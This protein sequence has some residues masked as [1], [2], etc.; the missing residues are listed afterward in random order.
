MEEKVHTGITKA[1]MERHGDYD[2]FLARHNKETRRRSTDECYTPAAVYDAVLAWVLANCPSVR[3]KKIVRPF[4]PEGDYKAEDYTDAVVIDNP[5]FFMEHQITTWYVRHGVPFFL[6]APALTLFT[7]ATVK[8]Q[9]TY[10]ATNAEVFYEHD[11]QIKVPIK[12]SFITNIEDLA[13][14]QLVTAPDLREAIMKAQSQNKGEYVP[15]KTEYHKNIVTPYRLSRV[16]EAGIQMRIPREEAAW[17]RGNVM[18][19]GRY[20]IYGGA[21]VVSDRHAAI[22]EKCNR[23]PE[24]KVRMYTPSD[25]A[26]N[27]V[28]GICSK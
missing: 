4:R 21:F 14:Y 23:K 17:W 27:K 8:D 13:S 20:N 1:Q 28:N 15:T 24:P 18:E 16:A 12:T 6:F 22:V 9:L 3:G 25:E 26:L 11:A 2:A 10:V 7:G 19:Q 5:P